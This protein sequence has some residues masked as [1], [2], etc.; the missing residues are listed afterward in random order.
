MGLKKGLA[1]AND[2]NY[3]PYVR[4]LKGEK[5]K[6]GVWVARDPV[7]GRIHRDEWAVRWTA[8]DA[9]DQVQSVIRDEFPEDN[10][11]I[12]AGWQAMSESSSGF[13]VSVYYHEMAVLNH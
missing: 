10:D 6:D 2:D 13:G 8:D 9:A 12:R 4:A 11:L 5:L 1:K 3:V 7:Y